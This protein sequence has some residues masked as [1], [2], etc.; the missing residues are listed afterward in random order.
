MKRKAT[1]ED[2][3][4]DVTSSMEI[5]PLAKPKINP[6]DPY[7]FCGFNIKSCYMTA[8]D[9][10]NILEKCSRG[11]HPIIAFKSLGKYNVYCHLLNL[12]ENF[13]DSL[14][15]R[16]IMVVERYY[17]DSLCNVMANV[18]AHACDKH[19]GQVS[20]NAAKLVMDLNQRLDNQMIPLIAMGSFY[21]AN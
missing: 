11:I 6:N 12:A 9:M 3:F 20:L 18:H 5:Q 2:P 7:D 17:F 19:G 4:A 8:Y 15:A 10:N 13:R 1:P 16:L 21:R 14:E